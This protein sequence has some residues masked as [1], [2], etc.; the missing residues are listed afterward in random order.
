[1][2]LYPLSFLKVIVSYS[3]ILRSYH[4]YVYSNPVPSH[5]KGKDLSKRLAAKERNMFLFAAFGAP[6]IV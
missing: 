5:F 3:L 6:M 4:K 1:M 2:K